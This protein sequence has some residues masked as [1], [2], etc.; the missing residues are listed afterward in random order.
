MLSTYVLFL[1][2]AAA[3]LAVVQLAVSSF[4]LRGI[5]GPFAA[6]FTDVWRFRAMRS[7]GWSERLVALHKKHGKLVRLGPNHVSVSDPA[8]IPVIYGTSPVWVKGPSYY[9]AATVSKGRTV[10][11]VIAMGETQHTAVRK[12]AGRHF[13]TNS[14]LDYEEPIQAATTELV[15]VLA[16]NPTADIANYLQCFAMDVLMRIAFSESLGFIEKGADVDGILAAV[17]ARFDHW[18]H[19]A[20]LPGADYLFNKSA[21]AGKLRKKGDSP[22]ASVSMEQ[23]LKRK[24][25][26]STTEKPD[27]MDLLQKFLDGQAKYPDIVS[28]DQILGIIMSTIGAGADTTAGTLAYTLYLLCKN[29]AATQKLQAELDNALADGTLT[30]PPTWPQVNKLPYLE[31]VLKE[32]M[33]VVPIASWGLDR[34]VP[35]GGA[36]IAGTYIPGGTVV[37]CQID[38][39][40]LDED[41][42]GRDAAAFRPERWLEADE[43]RKRRMDRAF[44]AFSAGKRTCTGIHIAWLEMKKTLPLLMMNFD[45][46]LVNPGQ[47]VRGEMRISAVKYPPPIW[48]RIRQRE[49]ASII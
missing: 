29:P 21:L 40:H 5:P 42:Y 36:T 9:G 48:M 27:R 28:D 34:V 15:R 20:A 18:G 3:A 45:M 26:M 47:D 7:K 31:A 2:V 37:G 1:L 44:L 22:L 6:R 17:V 35:A 25:A 24:G 8:A 16:R 19:W 46:E 12:S 23:L 4:K 10:P 32:S 33:R 41:I 11:S 13:T 14:L 30:N 38:S 43:D 49:N 39:V